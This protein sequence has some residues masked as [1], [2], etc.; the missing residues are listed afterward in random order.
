MIP[1]GKQKPLCFCAIEYATKSALKETIRFLL[2]RNRKNPQLIKA[3]SLR[4]ESAFQLQIYKV[5]LRHLK[6]LCLYTYR[7]VEDTLIFFLFFIRSCKSYSLHFWEVLSIYSYNSVAFEIWS[8]RTV[9]LW[10]RLK[11][12]DVTYNTHLEV[13]G[14]TR[15]QEKQV[16]SRTKSYSC[17]EVWVDKRCLLL[18]FGEGFECGIE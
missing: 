9:N 11:K 13:P 6:F 12:K 10:T 16:L 14:R 1:Y 8:F 2:R 15:M 18:W 17:D 5:F 3:Y 4:N 7:R